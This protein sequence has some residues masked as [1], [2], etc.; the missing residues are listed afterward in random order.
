MQSIQKTARGAGLLYLLVIIFGIFA[1]KYVRTT[2]ID[3]TD[4]TATVQNIREHPLLFRLG[5]LSDL[6][7]QL[8]Y[9][10]LPLVLYRFLREVHEWASYVM[11]LGVTVAVAIMCTNMLN[12]YAPLLLLE[13]MNY[14]DVQMSSTVLFYL[15]MHSKGYHIA[16]IF[17]GLWLWPLGYLVLRSGLFPRF[18][19]VLLMVGCFG[20][21]AD[22]ALYFIMPVENLSISGMLTLSADL[23]EFWLCLYLL[24]KGVKSRT[25]STRTK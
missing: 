19:G 11:V 17:F 23:G 25:F 5:F 2:L 10:M 20:Y 8:S 22:V 7:M 14:G 6:F 18:I 3:F 15:D 9:F 24:F 21:W 4:G 13:H 16:Q 1:E 12:H